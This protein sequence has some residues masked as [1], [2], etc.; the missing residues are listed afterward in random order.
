[1]RP[2]ARHS[3]SRERGRPGRFWNEPEII[4]ALRLIRGGHRE[5]A[6]EK[7]DTL[8]IVRSLGPD[9]FFTAEQRPRL[10]QLIARWRSARDASQSRSDDEQSELEHLIDA[11]VRAATERAEAL[12]HELAASRSVT[13]TIHNV[14]CRT[15]GFPLNGDQTLLLIKIVALHVSETVAALALDLQVQSKDLGRAMA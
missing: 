11:E 4:E 3:R 12:I 5:R 10:E 6:S 14:S 15:H 1:L 9:R 8:I 13:M 2:E 7:A